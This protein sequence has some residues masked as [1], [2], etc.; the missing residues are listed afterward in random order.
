MRCGGLRDAHFG[1]A[2]VGDQS[3]RPSVA[4][5]FGK[6][7]D[8]RGN[9]QGDVDQ[10]GVL[11]RRSEF[12]GERLVNGGA[13]LRFWDRLEAVPAGHAQVASEHLVFL[14]TTTEHEDGTS[15]GAAGDIDA[16]W[17]RT[18]YILS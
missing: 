18:S 8:G 17:E 10:I 6:K 2:S 13:G 4:R 11:E 3:I 5:D 1:A 15:D 9:G 14:D 16:I 12:T 7:V